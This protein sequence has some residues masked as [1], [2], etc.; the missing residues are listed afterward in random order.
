LPAWLPACFSYGFPMLFHRFY[1]LPGGKMR[2]PRFAVFCRVAMRPIECV[3]SIGVPAHLHHKGFLPGGLPGSLLGF[4]MFFPCFSLCFTHFPA[5]RY[6]SRG[7]PSAAAW[8]HPKKCVYFPGVP[9]HLHHKGFLPGGPPGSPPGFPM[10]FLCFSPGFTHSPGG[11]IQK[12]RCAVCC[13]LAAR[14]IECVNYWVLLRRSIVRGSCLVACLAPRL[15]FPCF[16]YAFPEVL[17]ISR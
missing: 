2:E 13:R 10:L 3:Y 9:V 4:P 11:K 12:P 6:K 5:G 8:R 16:S 7:V 15:A 14:P 1:L 17:F